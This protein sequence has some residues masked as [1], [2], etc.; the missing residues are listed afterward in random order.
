MR[1]IF[2]VCSAAVLGGCAG[3]ADQVQPSAQVPL[4]A[5]P[6]YY[7]EFWD[8]TRAEKKIIAKELAAE[9]KDPKSSRFKWAKYPKSSEAMVFYCGQ[10]NSKNSFGGYVGFRSYI[11]FVLNKNGKI[12]SAGL[13]G[14]EDS[15]SGTAVENMCREHGLDP[16]KAT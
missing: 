8:L 16:L 3:T 14:T 12:V 11:A 4:S 10:V 2:A 13:I 1:V 5:A 15:Q 7:S 9:L 6:V